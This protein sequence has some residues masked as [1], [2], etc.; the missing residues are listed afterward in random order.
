MPQF[1]LN[2]RPIPQGVA[3]NHLA[4][5]IGDNRVHRVRGIIQ[6]ALMGDKFAVKE[7]GEY[8]LHIGGENECGR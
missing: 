6:K 7:L 3:V 1:Y 2:N 8:G 5:W 4:N